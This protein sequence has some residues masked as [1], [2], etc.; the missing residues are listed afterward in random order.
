[1]T[2][3]SVDI[4]P[5]IGLVSVHFGATLAGDTLRVYASPVSQPCH[6]FAEPGGYGRTRKDTMA[7]EI[8][9]RRTLEEPAGHGRTRRT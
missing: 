6:A 5:R 3:P 8:E 7:G 4:K 1:M 2:P 9:Y